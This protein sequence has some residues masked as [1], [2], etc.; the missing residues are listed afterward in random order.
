MDTRQI[1]TDIRSALATAYGGHSQYGHAELARALAGHARNGRLVCYPAALDVAA[2]AEEAADQEVEQWEQMT[3]AD[4]AQ[5]VAA[6][7]AALEVATRAEAEPPRIQGHTLTPRQ[8]TVMRLLGAVEEIRD[9]YPLSDEG[10]VRYA[11]EALIG[12]F[13]ADEA[14][15]L[16]EIDAL[17]KTGPLLS[18]EGDLLRHSVPALRGEAA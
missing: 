8:I 14:E 15:T 3:E 11:A 17:Q 13:C 5:I 18:P 7:T 16:A 4:H 10:P 12:H 1:V 9:R 6:V 2:V